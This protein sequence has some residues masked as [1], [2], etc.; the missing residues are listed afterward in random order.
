MN[1]ILVEARAAEMAC[2]VEYKGQVVIQFLA[3]GKKLGAKYI[4]I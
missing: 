4:P 3:A 1:V 2:Q